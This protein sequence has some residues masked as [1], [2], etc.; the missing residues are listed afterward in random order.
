MTDC[1]TSLQVGC[2]FCLPTNPV[3]AVKKNGPQP[4][5]ITQWFQ[6][7]LIRQLTLEHWTPYCLHHL[8]G[9]ISPILVLTAVPQ[10][11]L[12]NCCISI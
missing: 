10:Q 2:C 8:S 6:S 12:S 11:Q 7:Y 4:E 1:S 3:K 9:D 5:K